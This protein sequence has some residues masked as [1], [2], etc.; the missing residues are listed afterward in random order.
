VLPVI[1]Y[2]TQKVARNFQLRQDSG[3]QNK[4]LALILIFRR[5]WKIFC[6]LLITFNYNHFPVCFTSC[7][8]KPDT[9]CFDCCLKTSLLSNIVIAF[10]A[11][12]W[13]L[14]LRLTIQ[15]KKLCDIMSA[16]CINRWMSSTDRA[17][18][19]EKLQEVMVWI[20]KNLWSGIALQRPLEKKLNWAS[21]FYVWQYSHPPCIS[22]ELTIFIF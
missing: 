13:I 8:T 20:C 12:V 21:I 7:S 11:D 18:L 22:L 14:H 3:Q 1:S 9:S 4:F 6:N 17:M 10:Q 16:H 19:L 2:N 15:L 5:I